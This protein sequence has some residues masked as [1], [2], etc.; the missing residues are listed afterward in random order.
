MNLFE[1]QAIFTQAGFYI[2]PIDGKWNQQLESAVRKAVP[3]SIKPGPKDEFHWCVDPKGFGVRANPSGKLTF[4][5]QGRLDPRK[6][7]ARI[8]IGPY[9]VFTVDQARE[10]A[11]GVALPAHGAARGLPAQSR[12]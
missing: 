7:P 2:G 5:V 9:G 8:T 1:I 10:L 4:I 12:H 3:N 6:P 11:R